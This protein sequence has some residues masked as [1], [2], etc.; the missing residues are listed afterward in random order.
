MAV[1]EQVNS[2]DP[3]KMTA[4]DIIRL[5][6]EIAAIADPTG[7]ASTVAA[8]SH[9]KCSQILDGIK[10]NQAKD[11]HAESQCKEDDDS[12]WAELCKKDSYYCDE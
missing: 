3:S 4:A 9:P 2:S 11:A 1:A 5:T 10:R 7:I 8:Y 6:A 12:C